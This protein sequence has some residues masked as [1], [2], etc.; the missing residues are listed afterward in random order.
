MRRSSRS[1]PV[2]SRLGIAPQAP[3]RAIAFKLWFACRDVGF[4]SGSPEVG[5]RQ[6]SFQ[7]T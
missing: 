1:Q 4:R 7:L 3:S 6:T 5:P 2:K